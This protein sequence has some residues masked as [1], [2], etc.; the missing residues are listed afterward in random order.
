[1]S[2]IKKQK[3]HLSDWPFMI[4]AIM[5]SLALTRVGSKLFAADSMPSTHKFAIIAAGFYDSDSKTFKK[6]RQ[7]DAIQTYNT[8][9]KSGYQ[10]TW[11]FK[12]ETGD[13]QGVAGALEQTLWNWSEHV[14]VSGYPIK[15]GDQVLVVIRAHGEPLLPARRSHR[16]S[17]GDGYMLDTIDLR[18][19]FNKFRK[20]GVKVALLDGSCYSGNSTELA[21]AG[22]CVISSQNRYNIGNIYHID[23]LP[24]TPWTFYDFDHSLNKALASNQ[25]NNLEE[26]FLQARKDLHD[27][28]PKVGDFNGVVDFFKKLH[29]ENDLPEISSAE[30]ALLRPIWDRLFSPDKV[31]NWDGDLRYLEPE[32]QIDS[33]VDEQFERLARTAYD[34]DSESYKKY[35][36]LKEK[37]INLINELSQMKGEASYNPASVDVQRKANLMKEL[38]S[39]ETEY[40]KILSR[41]FYNERDIYENMY[42]NLTRSGVPSNACRDFKL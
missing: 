30:N 23:P 7:K 19:Y 35:R 31:E 41:L 15:K 20:E 39:M 27:T 13:K 8:L 34:L 2:A 40:R 28:N 22:A 9:V 16:V 24:D 10:V 33:L 18:Q 4:V 5:M 3:M 25:G 12:G 14:G 37:R 17:F 21:S 36:Q 38:F 42:R 26:I 6:I 11:I 32:N 1:M 29:Y